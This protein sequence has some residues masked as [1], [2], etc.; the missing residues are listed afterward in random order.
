M[1]AGTIVD[2]R[3]QIAALAGSGGMGAVY[4][5]DELGTGKTVAIK[6]MHSNG[7]T[8]HARFLREAHVL[9]K[10]SHPAIVA[11]LGHGALPSGEPWIAMEWLEGETLAD[12]LE[13]GP[14]APAET[15]VIVRA[16]AGALE[17]AHAHGV[18]HRDIKPGNIILEAGE[19]AR[20]HLI[21]FGVARLRSAHSFTEFGTVL[22]TPAYMAPEQIRG[23]SEADERADLYALGVILFECSTGRLPFT[24]PNFI[25][26]MTQALFERPPRLR[27]INPTLSPALES[28]VDAL[29][30]KAPE[31]RLGPARAVY[32][33]L[34]RVDLEQ[35]V[36]RPSSPPKTQRLTEDELRFV[37]IVFVSR[38]VLPPESINAETLADPTEGQLVA[39]I[40]RIAA[41]LHGRVEGLRDGTIIVAFPAKGTATDQAAMAARTALAIH[42]L[43]LGLPITMATGR[44]SAQ[45][46]SLYSDAAIRASAL[47]AYCS[48]GATS[49]PM[50]ETTRGLLDMRFSVEHRDGAYFLMGEDPFGEPG[51]LLCGRPAPFVGREREVHLIEKIFEDVVHEPRAAAAIVV[52]E[53]G[54]GK[55]RLAHELLAHFSRNEPL[56]EIWVGRGVAGG[57]GGAFGMLAGALQRAADIHEGESTL[58]RHRKFAEFVEAR[59]P[60]PKSTSVI[61]FLGEIAEIREERSP[62]NV[63]LQA[64]RRDPVLMRDRIRFAF[65]DLVYGSTENRPLLLLLE[66]LHWGDLPSVKVLEAAA[67]RLRD[68]PVFILALGRPELFESFPKLL[69][70]WSPSTLRLAGLS[71]RACQ[72]LISRIV[73]N[74]VTNEVMASL[75]ERS[76]GHP[77][78]LEELVRII[79]EPSS[80]STNAMPETL[81]AMVQSRVAKVPAEARRVLRA[82]SIF[83]EVFWQAGV[84]ALLGETSTEQDVA[85][86]LGMLRD[87]EFVEAKRTSR[88][89]S[90]T[91]YRFRHALFREAAYGMLTDADKTTGH[92]LAGEFLENIGETSAA[93]L[94]AHYDIA[95]QPQRAA[96]YHLQ[97]ARDAS[98]GG[99][100]D[101]VKRHADQVIRH[102]SD[103]QQVGEARALKADAAQWQGEFESALQLSETAMQNL[104]RGSDKWFGAAMTLAVASLRLIKLDNHRELCTDLIQ[105]GSENEWTDAYIEAAVRIGL[106][107]YIGG[108]YQFALQLI[109]PLTR[110]L[111][112][113]SDYGPRIQALFE[114]L[115]A[116]NTTVEWRYDRT[117]KHSLE[118]ARLFEEVGDIRSAAGQRLDASFT[119]ID[120]GLFEK[121]IEICKELIVIAER[122]AIPRMKS[123][124]RAMLGTALLASGRV[125][126]SF[127]Y[128]MEAKEL[129]DGMSDARNGGSLRNKLGRFHRLRKE[130]EL[131]E[132]YL[133]EAEAMLSGL[134]RMR[135]M[136]HAHK[137]ILFVELKRENEALEH[138]VL[139]MKLL[140]QLG[141]IGTDEILVRFAYVQS[142]R[143]AR[144]YEEAERERIKARERLTWIA[145]RFDDESVRHAFLTRVDE[146]RLVAQMQAIVEIQPF[147]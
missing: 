129:L 41:P 92:A 6:I 75:I 4:R 144:R 141:R 125:D 13:R 109:K 23:A 72:N 143:F 119:L 115:Q 121:A 60:G 20:A 36:T 145:G 138:A 31:R 79:A 111:Q 74:R 47:C 5:A 9:T 132:K 46:G 15:L 38:D 50:D 56:T 108:Q 103:M 127:D 147:E 126:E 58:V 101:A 118:A 87:G 113:R 130:Y 78:F 131:A 57:T 53:A 59:V 81:L 64:A 128:L 77:L 32:E 34:H 146:N 45:V 39:A 63:E 91:E 14:L 136:T 49:I 71:Q 37:S 73:G 24:A 112:R 97:A 11:C 104:E 1:E 76:A 35:L 51:R 96:P 67:Q 69:T 105:W 122:L 21:D 33:A 22:G 106:Q 27:D 40:E 98:L 117:F 54:A 52:G 139:G 7:P 137:A 94:A 26:I 116:A 28:L 89:P 29:L 30:E 44:S 70:E 65:E 114:L 140:E 120:L 102:C 90:Q 123:I 95:E 17:T 85:T 82:A 124:S 66:D 8:E 99:D 110:L 18:V 16:I 100:F 61:T 83:G 133:D 93:Q 86:W 88:F 107:T 135:A 10:L 134:P 2:Q 43:G 3:F 84:H 142:L 68:R 12:K 80:T 42:D 62:E 19:P 25:G 55:S 48:S